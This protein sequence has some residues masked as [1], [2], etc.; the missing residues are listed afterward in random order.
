[1]S[2]YME[3]EHRGDRLPSPLQV[4]TDNFNFPPCSLPGTSPQPCVVSVVPSMT[5]TARV[6]QC[7]SGASSLPGEKW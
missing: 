1:M 5:T 6:R 4:V 7:Q 3:P 2:L